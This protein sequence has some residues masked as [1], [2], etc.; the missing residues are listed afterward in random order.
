VQCHGVGEMK[1]FAP[2]EA[3]AINFVH[4]SDR[5]TREYYDRWVYNPQRVVPGTRMPSFADSE[6]K[7][8]LKD[9]LGGDAKQQFDAIWSYLLLGKEMQPPE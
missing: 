2:F 9:T 3:P 4:V 8:A 5:L 1:A 6:G 7:T